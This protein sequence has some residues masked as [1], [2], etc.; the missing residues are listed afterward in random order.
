M[1]KYIK[2][3]V[4]FIIVNLFFKENVFSL[5][6]G[7]CEYSEIS[8]LK[9]YVT[10]V[11]V[12]YDHYIVNNR[13]YFNITI[14]NLLPEMY[15]IDSNTNKTYTYN[16]SVNGEIVINGVSRTSGNYK[17][18]SA[19]SRCYGVK[20][21][22]KYYKMPEYNYYY[23]NELCKGLEHLS[24]CKK[25]ADINYSSTD[26]KRIIEEYKESLNNTD[27]EENEIIHEKTYFDY[28]IEF[29]VKY[30]YFILIGIIVVCVIIMKIEKKKNSFDL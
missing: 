16:N 10:N 18:Y 24:V 7:G 15:F 28:I 30:Y 3:L 27:N 5:T 11:N 26:F 17:F 21:G 20:L 23:N 9:S 2:F 12:T 22:V 29:Y 13:A 25:W 6:Y 19:L 8:R 4:L 14:S 1:K